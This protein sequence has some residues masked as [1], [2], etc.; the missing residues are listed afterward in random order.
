MTTMLAFSGPHGGGG[1]HGSHGG[2]GG[3]GHGGGGGGHGGGGGGHHSGG[4]HH[5]HGGH[6]H[7]HGGRGNW[8]QGPWYNTSPDVYVIN[9]ISCP[10]V[11][12]PVLATDGLTYDN[13]CL[14]R[15][16][17]FDVV[18]Y[19]PTGV[20]GLGDDTVTV[21]SAKWKAMIV[22]STMGVVGVLVASALVFRAE[23]TPRKR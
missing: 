12:A 11:Y 3:G 5:G 15:T 7:P 18:R 20:S 6:S 23:L 17:G 9:Q 1:G 8:G 16:A 13:D 4:E 22:L 10:Q 14:A 2:H 21:P 19:L